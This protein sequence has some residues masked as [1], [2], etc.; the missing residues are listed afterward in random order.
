MTSEKYLYSEC[1]FSF[2]GEG[3]FTGVPCAWV[4]LFGCNFNCH[5]FGQADPTNPNTYHLPYAEFD[6]STVRVVEE[7]PVWNRGCDSSYSWSKKYRHLQRVGTASEIAGH[8]IELLESRW[9]AREFV[10]GTQ[11]AHLV[12]TGGEPLLR[13]GQQCI[14]ETIDALQNE[15][16]AQLRNVTIET[17]GTQPLRLGAYEDIR[18][19][20][21]IS[22]KL[23]TVSGERNGVRPHIIASYAAYAATNGGGGQLKFVVGNDARQWDELEAA[24]AAIRREGVTFDVWVMPVG[25]TTDGQD[26]VAADVANEAMRRGYYFSPRVHV[27]V[28]GNTIGT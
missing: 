17:N 2:Q 15:Y 18:I 11:D 3:A 10:R 4:R 24:V 13:R 19:F 9:G 23:Y 14:A 16:K 25:A 6:A 12:F 5:G 8:I 26:Q 27:Y 22:P 21:S 1:F 20:F 28:Y 7:L